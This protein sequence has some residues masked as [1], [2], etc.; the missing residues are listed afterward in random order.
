MA[1][2]SWEFICT[3]WADLIADAQHRDFVYC[4]PPYAGRFTDFFNGWTD[5]E[6]AKLEAQL[7]K[8]NC[9][10]L[11]SMWFQ[12]KYRK[13]ERL[14]ES[15]SGYEIKTFSHFYHLGATENLRN[16]MTEALVVG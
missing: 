5:E 9:P 12:N 2:K 6:A 1:G 14:H 4:D 16:V 3:D 10:F 11:Y 15:F 13:N 7:K 8:M